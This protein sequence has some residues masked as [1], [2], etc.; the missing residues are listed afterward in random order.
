MLTNILLQNKTSK[1]FYIAYQILSPKSKKNFW[2]VL[3]LSVI[4]MFLE[5]LGI[6]MI[7]PAIETF[8]KPQWVSHY[9]QLNS[10]SI[11]VGETNFI[12]IG[13]LTLVGI[14]LLKIFF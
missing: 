10:F 9:P 7:F 8:T 1:K 14:F 11:K 2:V 13:L 4:G 6:G 5:V 12:I 3:F